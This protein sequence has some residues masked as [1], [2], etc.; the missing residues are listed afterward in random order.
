MLDGFEYNNVGYLF[1]FYDFLTFRQFWFA[2][3]FKIIFIRQ[4]GR[5]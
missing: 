1:I 3:C 4:S 2:F 5:S